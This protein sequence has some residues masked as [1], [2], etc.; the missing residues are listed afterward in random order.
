MLEKAIFNFR[1]ALTLL[2]HTITLTLS[3]TDLALEFLAA[4]GE[5]GPVRCERGRVL[6]EVLQLAAQLLHRL[7]LEPL[8]RLELRTEAVD[9]TIGR[10]LV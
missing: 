6:L 9:R 5:H 10:A 7:V 3:L 4:S 1:Q 8:L 2:I